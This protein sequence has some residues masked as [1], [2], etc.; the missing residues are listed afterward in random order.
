LNRSHIVQH[1]IDSG[2]EKIHDFV[3]LKRAVAALFSSDP[4]LPGTAVPLV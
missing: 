2:I 4:D 1:R 3:G